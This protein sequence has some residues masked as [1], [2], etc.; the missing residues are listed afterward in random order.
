MYFMEL[1]TSQRRPFG[2]FLAY[3]LI[4]HQRVVGYDG[5]VLYLVMHVGDTF[6]AGVL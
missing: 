3:L 4:K 5:L 1:L 6:L 2:F